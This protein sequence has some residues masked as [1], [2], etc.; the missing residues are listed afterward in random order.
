MRTILLST[1]GAVSLLF[2]TVVGLAYSETAGSGVSAAKPALSKA[3]VKVHQFNGALLNLDLQG[4]RLVV[5]NKRTEAQFI[6][7]SE[8]AYKEGRRAVRPTNLKE[9]M[10]I[11]VRYI[12]RDGKRIART[13]TIVS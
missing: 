1:L 12:E 2:M 4:S 11:R 3:A 13:V 10:K 5:K 6:L 9:G 8:T 7:T